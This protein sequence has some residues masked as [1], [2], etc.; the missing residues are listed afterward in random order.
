MVT[1]SGVNSS[2]AKTA[3]KPSMNARAGAL[4]AL[5]SVA[6]APSPVKLIIDTDMSTDCD[7]VGALCIAHALEQ[8]GEAELLAVVHDTGVATGVGTYKQSA[9]T[10]DI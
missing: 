6:T 5:V 1:K 10:C 3:A 9:V 8:R 7:D 4:A 2:S